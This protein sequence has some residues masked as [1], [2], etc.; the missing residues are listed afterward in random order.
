LLDSL[1]IQQN[2]MRQKKKPKEKW[3]DGKMLKEK[4]T[5]IFT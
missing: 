3:K 1:S 4:F 2:D 5:R